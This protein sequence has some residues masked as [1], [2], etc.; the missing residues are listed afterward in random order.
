MGFHFHAHTFNIWWPWKVSMHILV[1]CII[2]CDNIAHFQDTIHW[3]YEICTVTFQ[4]HSMSKVLAPKWKPMYEHLSLYIQ[5]ECLSLTIFKIQYI[6]NLKS[7][8]WPF[9][10]I[11][12]KRSGRQ[13]KVIWVPTRPYMQTICLSLT[14]FKIQ[15][16]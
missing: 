3:K 12:D 11:Q 13:M 10:V 4:G 7:A 15:S 2:V 6:E 1:C 16:I 5:I 8:L 14:I 9:K